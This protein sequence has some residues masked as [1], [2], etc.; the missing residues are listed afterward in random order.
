[1]LTKPIQ[2]MT[3]TVVEVLFACDDD[4]PSEAEVQSWVTRAIEGVGPPLPGTTEVSVRIVD[5]DEMQELNRDFRGADKPTNVLAFPTGDQP[6]IPKAE[7]RNLGDIAICAAV[8][9][10]EAETQGK[11]PDDHWAHM[12]VHGTL[13]LLGFDHIEDRDAAEMEAWE[14]RILSS[15]GIDNPYRVQ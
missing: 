14:V 7:H 11:R 3:D 12:I 9:A 1:M 2:A 5:A 6:M 4:A 10:G 15:H 13:H 8:V